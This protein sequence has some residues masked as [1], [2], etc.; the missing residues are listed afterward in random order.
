MRQ[1]KGRLSLWIIIGALGAVIMC[2]GIITSSP[3]NAQITVDNVILNFSSAAKPVQNV[4]VHNSS[5]TTLYVNVNAQLIEKPGVDGSP[6]TP[7]EN[8]LVSPKKFSVPGGGERS[9][10][11]LLK[12]SPAEHEEVYRVTFS[13]QDKGFGDEVEVVSENTKALIRVL[14]GMGILVFADPIAPTVKL[15]WT[16]AH[17]KITFHND[18]NLHVR[19]VQVKACMKEDVECT[20]LPARRIYG[21]TTV[22]MDLDDQKTLYVT[23]R[24][25][26]SGDFQKLVIPPSS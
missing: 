8:L 26:T 19:L 13:P 17:G 18:G 2:S 22:S 24:E 3:A 11:L 12:K 14:T 20:D 10:R 9:V 25:G 7:A 21:G 4:I 6:T 5:P 1:Q 15:S 23:K 16:R